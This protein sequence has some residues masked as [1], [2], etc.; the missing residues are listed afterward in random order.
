M[1]EE[2]NIIMKIYKFTIGNIINKF[3]RTD[4]A[5]KSDDKLNNKDKDKDNNLIDNINDLSYEPPSY[6]D[7]INN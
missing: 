2:N 7:I 5:D 3:N 1:C 4:R 6:N